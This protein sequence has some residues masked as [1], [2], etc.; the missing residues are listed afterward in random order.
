M[1]LAFTPSI[2]QRGMRIAPP[3]AASIPITIFSVAAISL[4]LAAAQAFGY[5]SRQTGTWI[6][7]LYA[8]PGLASILLTLRYR[9]PLLVAWH[10]AVLA[11]L[12]SL[13]RTIPSSDLLGAMIAVGVVVAM[14]GALGLTPRVA[15]LV[16]TP[17][18][19][20]VV[21]GNVLPFVV[22]T[23]EALNTESL[24][25]GA[26]LA[27]FLIGRRVLPPR[28]PA[29]LPALVAGVALAAAT[30]RLHGLA[31]GWV[32]PDLTPSIPT[33]SPSA[34]LTV[35]PIAVPLI[36]LHANLTAVAYMRSQGYA[37]PARAIEITTGLATVAA[38]F[39][40]PCPICMGALVTPL[41]AGPEAG[42]RSARPVAAY[43]SAVGF[44]LV[45]VAAGVA[46][47][48][49]SLMPLP[50]LLAVAGLA[51]LGVLSQALEQIVT[52]P[53][54]LGPLVAFAVASSSL[55][56]FGL[57]A[58]FWALVFGALA[59]FLAESEAWR[60]VGKPGL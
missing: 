1:G 56:L 37:P 2:L 4:P 55:T 44:L 47:D 50:L 26:T 21:A 13:G 45:A 23:F 11:F 29:I 48:L 59:S 10:V 32:W 33:L 46:A 30:G 27:A 9:Q 40:G 3:L 17:V 25:V 12:A 35:V 22:G 42:E 5:S 20:G 43:A 49:P 51:L 24:L 41:T 7:A 15:E 58:A 14:L 60:Q 8:A 18:V 34:I 39:F 19:F 16:P 57:G 52:G 53:L 54:R 38:S 31:A 36:A 6:F 28:A